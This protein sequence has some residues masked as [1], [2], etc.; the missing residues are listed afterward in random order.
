MSLTCPDMASLCIAAFGEWIDGKDDVVF[1]MPMC[2]AD[3]ILIPANKFHV[4]DR[5]LCFD[6]IFRSLAKAVP[7]AGRQPGRVAGSVQLHHSA[8]VSSAF[9]VRVDVVAVNII[10]QS[11]NVPLLVPRLVL[12]SAAGSS[13]SLAK[14]KPVKVCVLSDGLG[15]LLIAASRNHLYSNPHPR[16]VILHLHRNKVLSQ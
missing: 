7:S 1:S 8:D 5:M 12:A 11:D 16:A 14:P 13:V 3:D 6:F 2:R 15:L 4:A 10:F 9:Q